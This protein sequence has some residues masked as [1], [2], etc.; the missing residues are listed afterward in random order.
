M[1]LKN[2]I[3]LLK[4]NTALQRIL[5]LSLLATPFINYLL[6][7]YQPY[8]IQAHVPGIWLGIALSLASFLGVL[9]S[10]YAYL[11]EKTCGVRK[12]ILIAT[13]LP[14]VF[15]MLMATISSSWIAILLFIGAYSSMNLQK[16]MF[17]DYINRHIESK[18]RATVLSLIS[19]VSGLYIAF[20]GLIIGG[21]ADVSLS[22][23]FLV[24]GSII[25][26]STLLIK[27]EH[28]HVT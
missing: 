5:L 19:M 18:N 26:I 22:F 25:I 9:T 21:I 28:V 13:L 6:N 17:A 20:M 2:G 7:F 16:P 4:S 3:M 12:G 1:L 14:G 10:K 23:A 15:Y 8:F 11:L 24:M 27:I